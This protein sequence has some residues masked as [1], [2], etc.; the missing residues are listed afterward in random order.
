MLAIAALGAVISLNAG[1]AQSWGQG[2]PSSVHMEDLVACLSFPQGF[3]I[4]TATRNPHRDPEELKI[5]TGP[6]GGKII[7]DRGECCG[8]RYMIP[9]NNEGTLLLTL[10]D[11]G[12]PTRVFHIKDRSVRQVMDNSG[13]PEP[14]GNKGTLMLHQ[15]RRMVGNLIIP[16]EAELWQ[17]SEKKGEFELKATAPYEHRYRDLAKFLDSE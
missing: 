13:W 12:A 17:W 5:L 11:G 9:L 10:W 4:V 3:A 6:T 7:F 14:V 2:S 16:T 15:G 8:L 1:S